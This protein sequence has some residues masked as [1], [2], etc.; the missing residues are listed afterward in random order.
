MA[1]APADQVEQLFDRLNTALKNNQAK[2]GLKAVDESEQ[3]DSLW[4]GSELPQ[5]IGPSRT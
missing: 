3:D 1:Q 4:K 2:R 5:G